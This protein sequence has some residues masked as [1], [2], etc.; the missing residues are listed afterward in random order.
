MP[1]TPFGGFSFGKN[2]WK[3]DWLFFHA[4]TAGLGKYCRAAIAELWSKRDKSELVA[5]ILCPHIMQLV[6][7][8]SNLKMPHF[9][10]L[11]Y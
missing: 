11:G 5:R 6:L 9:S 4:A 2:L 8:D 1:L 3:N 10:I 7:C